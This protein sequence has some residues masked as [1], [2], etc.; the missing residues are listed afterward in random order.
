LALVLQQL[1]CFTSVK[2]RYDT[3]EPRLKWAIGPFGSLVLVPGT[4]STI[5]ETLPAFKKQLKLY[6]ISNPKH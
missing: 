1:S 2:L 5:W 4:V 6:L 3:Q